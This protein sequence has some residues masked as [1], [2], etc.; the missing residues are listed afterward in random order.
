MNALESS[1]LQALHTNDAP[2]IRAVRSQVDAG[3]LEQEN[4]DRFSEVSYLMFNTS[5]APFDSLTARQAVAKALNRDEM[6]SVLFMDQMKIA[7]GP[8][9][10][11]VAGYLEDTGFPAYDGEAAAALAEQYEQETGSP[12]EFSLSSSSS[13]ETLQITSFIQ[14]QM[15]KAGIKVTL[16]PIEQSQQISTALGDDWQVQYW[17]NHP[18]GDPDTQY[19]WWYG[20]SPVNFGKF[21]DPEINALLDEGRSMPDQ[22]ERDKVYQ[23][24]NRL[25]AQKLYSVWTNWSNWTI[26][27]SPQVGGVLGPDLPDGSAPFPG[28]ATGHPV[29]GMWIDQ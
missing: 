20:G 23:E 7:S 10:P 22:P 24:V 19:Y 21:D 16:D 8:F 5:K 3:A 6:Q 9:A 11:G 15:A 17:R 25:F 2:T 26:A 28:L 27:T 13:G 18:G 14:D 4:T 1:Q 29:S 12:L